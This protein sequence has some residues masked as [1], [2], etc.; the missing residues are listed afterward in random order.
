M[1]PCLD[2]DTSS[3]C[4]AFPDSAK[5]HLA[6][7]G[8]LNV[9]LERASD[10]FP[11]CGAMVEIHG[12]PWLGSHWVRKRP[13]SVSQNKRADPEWGPSLG[14][15]RAVGEAS[16]NPV[17]QGVLFSGLEK[18][19]SREEVAPVHLQYSLTW[20]LNSQETIFSFS[21]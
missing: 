20:L 12:W 4:L 8:G 3:T 6:W 19:L 21:Y 1:P 11:L 7:S 15:G 17:R 13:E 16:K 2:F 18:Q 10:F 14:Q 5:Y 9:N